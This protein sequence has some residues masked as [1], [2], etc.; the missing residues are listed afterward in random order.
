MSESIRG[1]FNQ[2]FFQRSLTAEATVTQSRVPTTA[3][4]V[5]GLQLELLNSALHCLIIPTGR[6][7]S[8]TPKYL[9]YRQTFGHRQPKF[10][11]STAVFADGGH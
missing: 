5:A 4:E 11:V 6:H 2:D 8:Y 9:G 7:Q 10:I 3:R 1:I